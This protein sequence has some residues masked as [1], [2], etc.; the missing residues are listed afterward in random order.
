LR[1]LVTGCAGF[2]GSHLCDRLLADGHVVVGIDAFTSYYARALKEQNLSDARREAE[3]TLIE[4]DLLTLDL[5]SLLEGIDVVLHQAAQAGVR[6]SWGSDFETYTRHNIVA[7]QR[8][9]DACRAQPQLQ[10]FVFASSSSIYGNAQ[11]LPVSED[12]V[13]R[14]FS[15]YGVT[16]LAAEHLCQVYWSNYR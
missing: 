14:P 4:G 11:T 8:L 2:I 9:L 10:R 5:E 7:A 15:P 13:P 1:C 12:A 6:A 3:F 16:K